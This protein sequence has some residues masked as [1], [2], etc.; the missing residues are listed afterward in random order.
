MVAPEDNTTT[1]KGSHLVE[2]RESPSIEVTKNTKGY[3]YTVKILSND[4]KRIK[5]LTDMLNQIYSGSEE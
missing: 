4:V 5:E 2:V 1:I 3:N